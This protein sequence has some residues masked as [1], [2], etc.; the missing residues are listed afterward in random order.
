MRVSQVRRVFYQN[1][2]IGGQSGAPVY[3]N[4]TGCG[5]CSMAVHAYG[6]YNGPPFSTNNH[7]T[8]ITQS[9]FNNL[10]AWKNAP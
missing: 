2:T 1:D 8:R 4:R 7:G 9:V 10:Q 6:T 5:I 3:Y